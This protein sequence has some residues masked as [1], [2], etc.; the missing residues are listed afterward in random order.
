MK[1]KYEDKDDEWK[2]DN[3]EA[4]KCGESVINKTEAEEALTDCLMSINFPIKFIKYVIGTKI[5]Y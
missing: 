3:S 4:P 5:S 1:K 2:T